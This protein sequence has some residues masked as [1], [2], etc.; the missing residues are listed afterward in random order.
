MHTSRLALAWTHL[1]LALVCSV[2]QADTIYKTVGPDGRITF[3][4]RALNEFAQAVPLRSPGKTPPGANLS[5]DLRQVSNRFPVVLYTGNNC[6]PCAR[7]RDFLG[8]RGVPFAERTVTTSADI[9]ALR[10]LNPSAGLPFAQI[11]GQQLSGYAESEWTQYLDAAGYPPQSQLP[12][13]Y[14]QP[15]AQPLVEVQRSEPEPPPR[16]L[17]PLYAPLPAASDRP[18]PQNPAGIRF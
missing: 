13:S 7:A 8:R 14:R 6:P 5:F 1:A 16:P 3:S 15:A 9:D 10:R 18:T 12:S 17:E 2:A 4:D 11:G